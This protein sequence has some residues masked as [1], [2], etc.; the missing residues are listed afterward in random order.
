MIL[1]NLQK[2]LDGNSKRTA[3]TTTEPDGRYSCTLVVEG[4]GVVGKAISV[5]LDRAIEKSLERY[6]EY[7]KPDPRQTTLEM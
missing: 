6:A 2:F 1:Y 7:L 5:T 3:M 4:T